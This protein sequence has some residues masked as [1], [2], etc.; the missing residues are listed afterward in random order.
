MS[1]YH[2]LM[3][4]VK[5]FVH[6]RPLKR[7]LL[8]YRVWTVSLVMSPGFG[9]ARHAFNARQGG[10]ERRGV[11][12]GRQCW[13]AEVVAGG[14]GGEQTRLMVSHSLP[15]AKHR[16][17]AGLLQSHNGKSNSISP[18]PLFLPPPLS[19]PFRLLWWEFKQHLISGIYSVCS[20]TKWAFYELPAS[21]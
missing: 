19:P 8:F 5:W 4:P 3:V 1:F 17:N 2:L 16:I 6:L 21:P 18:P 9:H 14:E 7:H 11:G 20:C 15:S 12:G 13:V 10:E